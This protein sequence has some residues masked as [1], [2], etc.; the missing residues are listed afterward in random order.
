MG[1]APYFDRNIQ[2]A[3]AVLQGGASSEFA[4]R[5][6]QNVVGIAFD[7]LA[8]QGPEGIALL[9]LL[10][11]MIGRLYPRIKIA[12]IDDGAEDKKFALSELA[13][14]IN[15]NIELVGDSLAVSHWL[16][17]GGTRLQRT[18][19]GAS[20]LY[21][22]SDNWI[23]RLS[24]T[25]PS[26]SGSTLNPFGP[27]VAAA[28]GAANLF[29]R[30]FSDQLGGAIADKDVSLSAY[31][32]LPTTQAQNPKLQRVHLGDVVL[33]GSGAIGSGFLWALRRL[34]ARGRLA[35]VDMDQLDSTNLQRYVLA[36]PADVGKSKAELAVR[37]MA[38]SSVDV[39][40]FNVTW[41]EYMSS[42]TSWDLPV[43]AVA[44]D[45]AKVR[46]QVQSSLP[47]WTFNAWTQAGEAGVS[48]HRFADGNACL[49]CLYM[50]KGHAP[51]QDQI[52]VAALRLPKDEI[53]L[54]N[55][56]QRLETGQPTERAFLEQIAT[57]N[58]LDVDCLIPFEGRPLC[59]F[60]VEAICGGKIL[61]FSSSDLAQN[62][63]VPMAF[64]S[65][66]AGI[67]MAA[68]VA[69]KGARRKI[70]TITQ[71]DLMRP[72]GSVLTSPRRPDGS[73]RCICSDPD[74]VGRY[75][76]KYPRSSARGKRTKSALT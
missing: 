17:V 74:F 62:V 19:R 37:F 24:D 27:G 8:A 70:Q 3:G 36:L 30:V 47:D 76:A 21:L 51:N 4:R 15:P 26:P 9:D 48:R 38:S 42:R 50:P 55:V 23:G 1:L 59:D 71:I 57:A 60:Y 61:E 69:S 25:K 5:L 40:A 64:Q 58:H 2:A 52:V 65:A 31:D 35:V 43:V 34:D 56:R 33:V 13:K 49:A 18:K 39:S 12:A 7:G 73:G 63:E 10:I 44:A 54:R 45:N 22:S 72:M 41:E 32:L 20:V 67:L 66:L 46:I 53:T 29:R 75:R 11:R 14:K 16:I 68:D 6:E 28:L